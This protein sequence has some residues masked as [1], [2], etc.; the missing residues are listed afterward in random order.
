[1]LR[2][3]KPLTDNLLLSASWGAFAS[4]GAM[5]MP[6]LDEVDNRELY[7][8]TLAAR[9]RAALALDVRRAEADKPTTFTSVFGNP[10]DEIMARHAG[11]NGAADVY[12][13]LYGGKPVGI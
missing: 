11:V 5:E 7:V 12:A 3:V 8:R 1:M 6:P 13:E 10:F 9:R 2:A 4:H